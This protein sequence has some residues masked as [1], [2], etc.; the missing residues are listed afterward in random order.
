MESM[1][2]LI[3]GAAEERAASREHELNILKAG[4]AGASGVAHGA[5]GKEGGAANDGLSETPATVDCPKC[6]RTLSAKANF[7]TGCGHKMRT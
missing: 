7:C 2:E 1:R 6:G 4:M 5:G 3:K